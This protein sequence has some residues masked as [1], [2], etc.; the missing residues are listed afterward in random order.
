MVSKSIEKLVS[1]NSIIRKMFEEGKILKEKYGEENVFD[2]SIGNPSVE[3]PGEV[4]ETIKKVIEEVDVHAYMNNAGYEDVRKTIAQSLNTRFNT[5]FN[6]QNIIMCTGAAGGINT[7]LRTLLNPDDEV[8]VLIPYFM[9]YKNYVENYQGKV[10]EVDCNKEW[11]PDLRELEDK[12]TAKTKAVIINNPNNPSGIVFSEKTIKDIAEVLNKKQKE[13]GTSICIISDEPYREIAFDNIEIPYITKY[14]NNTIVV[15]SYSKSLSIPGERIGYIVI[16]N[17]IDD[18]EEVIQGIT[19]A[20]RILGFVNA[21]SLMQKVIRECL[22]ITADMSV[23]EKNRNILYEGLTNIG[24]ECIKP[25]GTFYLFFKSPIEDD[26]EFCQLAKKFN[27]LMVAGSAFA[28]PGY[29]RLAF[30]TETEKIINSL[31]RFKELYEQITK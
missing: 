21:P 30:C 9:E 29:V 5:S 20:N 23:Y 2:F 7:V 10:I 8:I 25:Q 27:I 19:I 3:V 11:N 12:I 18:F 16:P 14:Y 22:E 28:K 6:S 26:K 24:Y 15:Y 4:N 13:Y 17:E 31:P 1:N